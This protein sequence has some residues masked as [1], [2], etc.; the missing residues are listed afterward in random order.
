MLLELLRCPIVQAPMAGGVSTPALVAA[1]SQAGGLGFLAAGYKTAEAMRAEIQA[2]RMLTK[3]PFGVNLFVPQR[4]DV[5]LDA[6]HRFRKLLNDEGRRLGVEPGEAV[7]NDDDWDA[8]LDLL[9]REPVPVVSFTFG[10]PPPD[11]IAELKKRGSCVV[12]TVTTPSEALAAS[13]AGADAL[14]VQGVEAGG[15]RASFSSRSSE[16]YGL[17]VLLRLIRHEVHLPLIAA[18]GIMHG[19]D[20][21][22]VL[23]AGACAAQMG[24]AFLRCPESGAH[25]LHK[26]ALADARY[27][28]TTLT[29]A[30]TGRRARALVNRFVRQYDEAAPAAYPHL[31]HMTQPLRRAAAAA[32]DPDG[33]SLWAGQGYRLARDLPAAELVR[34]LMD[35]TRHALAEAPA[36]MRRP[37]L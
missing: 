2:V 6:V 18:G 25:P 22:A 3:A 12:V 15:H 20:I 10:C 16:D 17:L 33:M 27:T 8:K 36:V 14:C 30:F 1:V 21:A 9:M 19:R 35:E 26:A 37:A 4:D 24:T 29:R 5:D 11:V 34:Q 31:H 13:R 32:G 28:V 23:A 7:S